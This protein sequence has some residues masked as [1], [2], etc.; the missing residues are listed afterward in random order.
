MQSWSI[1]L[2]ISLRPCPGALTSRLTFSAS[3][4]SPLWRSLH[5]QLEVGGLTQINNDF[6]S[7]SIPFRYSCWHQRIIH[8][9]S[10]LKH[11]H[12]WRTW[13]AQIPVSSAWLPWKSVNS[14]HHRTITTS[15]N[16]L[17]SRMFPWQW[18]A[19]HCTRNSVNLTFFFSLEYPCG[20]SPECVQRNSR[21]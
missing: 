8:I 2:P 9:I 17:V 7:I 13:L 19:R 18:A 21:L 15:G 5:S 6:H 10:D 4:I 14:H 1:M 11:T 16:L 20:E 12:E 3:P